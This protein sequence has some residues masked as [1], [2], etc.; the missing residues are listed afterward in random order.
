[1]RQGRTELFATAFVFAV[2]L[3]KIIEINKLYLTTVV[4]HEHLRPTK[5]GSASL[6]VEAKAVDYG[7]RVV[8]S[9]FVSSL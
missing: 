6:V 3:D 7:I 2:G 9:F 8:P 5:Y 4:L 1:M